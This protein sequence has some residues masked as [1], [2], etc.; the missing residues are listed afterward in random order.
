MT[1]PQEIRCYKEIRNVSEAN[2]IDLCSLIDNE[3]WIDVFQENDMES[4]FNCYFNL[5]CQKVRRNI[6]KFFEC[7]LDK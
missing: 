3:T 5:V 2:M 7:S 1:V 4:I 6:V